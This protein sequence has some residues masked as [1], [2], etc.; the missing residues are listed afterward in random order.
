MN[1]SVDIRVVQV[2]LKS[3]C[4]CYL[5]NYYRDIYFVTSIEV[6]QK[7]NSPAFQLV[8]RGAGCS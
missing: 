2:F 3:V 5:Q 8:L 1:N 7:V 4:K 6:Y